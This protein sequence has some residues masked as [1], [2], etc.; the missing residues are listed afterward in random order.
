MLSLP[1]PLSAQTYV[2]AAA[3]RRGISL[4]VIGE[5]LAFSHQY[6][7]YL[8]LKFEKYHGSIDFS[9]SRIQ[10]RRAVKTFVQCRTCGKQ[11]WER[12][13]R[14]VSRIGYCSTKCHSLSQR[15][16]VRNEIIW[17]IDRRSTTIDTWRDI[18]RFLKTD[19]QTVQ[20]SIWRFLHENGILTHKNVN[21]IWHSTWGTG[22]PGGEKKW[23]ER[24][25][26]L[27]PT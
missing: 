8:V 12:T 13:G 15:C 24:R 21:K 4:R 1:P 2:V 22:R 14:S 10:P 17:A 23:L 26:G 16:L 9:P 25:T 5:A 27:E 7:R 19:Y 18:E 20:V 6:A 11:F 3:R